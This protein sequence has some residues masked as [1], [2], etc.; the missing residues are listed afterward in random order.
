MNLVPRQ[1]TAERGSVNPVCCKVSTVTCAESFRVSRKKKPSTKRV[2]GLFTF[3]FIIFRAGHH[4]LAPSLP[5]P[6]TRETFPEDS[7]WDRCPFPPR[8]CAPGGWQRQFGNSEEGG[9]RVSSGGRQTNRHRETYDVD[10]A[11]WRGWLTIILASLDVT[12]DSPTAE[13]KDNG[14]KTMKRY[15]H[16]CVCVRARAFRSRRR[17]RRI[18]DPKPS[19]DHWP[20]WA[21]GSLRVWTFKRRRALIPNSWWS[22][23]NNGVEHKQTRARAH[24]DA[25]TL[26]E[27]AV[28]WFAGWVRVLI[29]SLT[30]FIRNGRAAPKCAPS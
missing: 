10:G 1:K 6:D 21:S 23:H 28:N 14:G 26:T 27:F 13:L 9:R 19:T 2:G 22:E 3:L 24:N 20:L 25:S 8:S 15:G 7:P 12:L 16:V 18:F 5:R 30:N 11:N 17:S 4:H 29:N